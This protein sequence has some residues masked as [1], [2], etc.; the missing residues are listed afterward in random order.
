MSCTAHP[1]AAGAGSPR[2]LSSAP[3]RLGNP[4]GVLAG[5]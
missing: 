1:H 2:A 5:E 4:I 3:V